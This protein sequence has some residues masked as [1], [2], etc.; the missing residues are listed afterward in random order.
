MRKADTCFDP[1]LLTRE[2]IDVKRHKAKYPE[3]QG[4]VSG[5]IARQALHTSKAPQQFSQRFAN[6]EDRTAASLR[7]SQLNQ[8]M[9]SAPLSASAEHTLALH[10]YRAQDE[11]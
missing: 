3:S 9:Q 11:H 8:L 6:C 5:L 2:H 10:V 7:A 1:R 4:A